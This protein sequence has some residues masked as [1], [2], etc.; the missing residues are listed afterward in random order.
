MSHIIKVKNSDGS[1]RDIEVQ[2]NETVSIVE[3]EI[4]FIDEV[5][6]AVELQ[7]TDNNG[8]EIT[9]ANGDSIVLE[10]LV[11]L[12]ANQ[13]D[14]PVAVLNF[15]TE[16]LELQSIDTYEKLIAA[17][18]ASAAGEENDELETNTLQYVTNDLPLNQG[19]NNSDTDENIRSRSQLNQEVLLEEK[20]DY[21]QII[22]DEVEDNFSVVTSAESLYASVN[23]SFDSTTDALA[24]LNEA[25]E[26]Y[27][28]LSTEIT[29]VKSRVDYN[30]NDS[31]EDLV[32]IMPLL[33][34]A[35]REHMDAADKYHEKIQLVKVDIDKALVSA[36]NAIDVSKSIAQRAE[37]FGVNNSTLNDMVQRAQK[38]FDHIKE[39]HSKN[40]DAI[41][42]A[43][44][45]MAKARENFDASEQLENDVKTDIEAILERANERASEELSE[46]DDA[47][48][49]ANLSELAVEELEEK[50]NTT[51]SEL[52]SLITRVEDSKENV[53]NKVT[54]DTSKELASNAVDMAKEYFDT[55]VDQ[56]QKAED[57]LSKANL[58]KKEALE[59]VRSAEDAYRKS[60]IA[61]EDSDAEVIALNSAKAALDEAESEISEAK[62]DLQTAKDEV[63]MALKKVE[64][65]NTLNSEINN[66]NLGPDANNDTTL[67]NE[68]TTLLIEPSTLLSNDTDEDGDTLTIT[69]VEATENTHGTVSINDEGKVVF[70]PESNYNGETSFNYTISDG[71]G[72]TSSAVVTV[73]VID[74]N[75]APTLTVESTKSV[76]ED[77]TTS[78]TYSASDIDGTATVTA[79]ALHGTVTVNNDGTITYT[80]DANYNGADTITV[81]ATDDD[82]SVVTQTSSITVND[83][84]DAP[85]L[86]VESTKSVNEDGTTSITYSA[87]DI[88]GTATVTATALHGTV[89]V[90]N[91]GTITYTPDANYNG[92]DTITVTATDDDGSVVTQ[93]S[94]ITVN[95]IND[96]PTLTVESTKSVNEDGTTSITYSASDIDGTATVTATALHGTVTVNNDGTITY[97]PDANYNGADTITVTATDDDG[98]VVTQTSSITVNDINDAPT[99]T[100][101]ST[102]SVNEDGTTSITY[103]ASD[104][105]GT[106]TVTATALHG[107]VTVNN[108]GTITYTPDANYNG[109]DTITVTATDDDGSVVTQTSSITVND[110]NDAPVITVGDVTAVED[111]SQVIANV[112]DIDGTI[113]SSNL[114][115][116]NGT[117]TIA[118][119]GDITYTPNANYN[120]TDSVTIE[121][122]DNDGTTTTQTFD[123]DV[124]A[125][126]DGPVA[127]D[128]SP[129]NSQ[130]I[131]AVS[132]GGLGHGIV[133]MDGASGSGYIMYSS[134]NVH[135]RFSDNAIH[136]GNATNLVAVKNIDGQWYY[137]TNTKLVAFT[138]QDGDRLVAEVDFSADT[139][140]MLSGITDTSHQINGINAGYVDGDLAITANRWAG[141]SNAGEFGITG[142]TINVQS[143]DGSLQTNEDNSITIEPSTLLENDS[144]IDGDTLTI[145]SVDAT[146]NTH[147]TVTINED[148]KVVF[149]PDA[150]YNGAASF[151]YT[152]SDGNG[153]TSSA[154]VN[155]NVTS[156]NDLPE[157]TV[158][159]TATVNEDGTLTISS[160]SF[161]ITDVEDGIVA[162]TLSADNGTVEI[163][164]G[165]IVYTPDANYNGT[166]TITVTATDSDGGI[167]TETIAVFVEAVNDG[168]VAVDDSG[169]STVMINENG[170]D[171]A[172]VFDS[173]GDNPELLGGATSV[174]V[175]M[176]ISSTSNNSNSLLSYASS[177][178]NNDFLVF[179]N[180]AG[181]AIGIYVDG[182]S[183][184][185]GIDGSIYD[186]EEKEISVSWD[187]ATGLTSVFVNGEQQGRTV[188]LAK[189]H[190][191]GEDGVL[192]LGQEQDSTGGS[193][194]AN[195]VFSGEY[196]D[197]SISVNGEEKAHWEMQSNS[198]NKIVDSTG[199]YDLSIVG[200]VSVSSINT[201]ISEDTTLLIEPS[202]LLSND[203]D[204]DGD[205][206]TITSVEATENTHG[207]V[208]INDEGKVVFTPESNYNGETS[209]NYTISDGNGGTSSAVVTVSVIDINDA[210]TLTVESTKSV[211][212]DG[213]TSIT[214]SASDIDGTATVTA[215][216]L[217]GTVTVNND[218][219]ITYTPD[220]NYN[221]ADTITVTATDD[222][223]SVVTQTSSITVNDINDAPVITV[224]DVTAVE[225]VSQVIANV[226]DI[227]GTIDS[228]NLT[229]NNGT[230][231]IADNGDITYTPNANYN[232]TD[233]VTIEVTDNDGTTTTQTFDVD[234]AAVNDGPTANDDSTN[235]MVF[236]GSTGYVSSGD[237]L[238]NVF[239][240]S[241]NSFSITANL[242]PESLSEAKT[243]H[244]IKNVFAAKASDSY[245]D[246]F[247]IGIDTDGS[248]LVYIDTVGADTYVDIGNP[249]DIIV[250]EN[251]FISVSYDNGVL[252]ANINGNE[253]TNDTT[254]TTSN[255][256][257][258]Q[259]VGSP[260]TVGASVHI[261]TFFKG[262]IDD[263]QVHSKA[264]SSDEVSTLQ[265][266]GT[267]TNGLELGYNF[268][269]STPLLDS[270]GNGL[271]GT[272]SGTVTSDE[273]ST[274]E[275]TDLVLDTAILLAND[276]DIDGG[277]LTVAS[278]QDATNGSVR[279]EN[280]EVV[281][282]PE[283]NYNGVATFTYTISDGQGGTDTATVTLNVASVNDKPEI[284]T[285]STVTMNEDGTQNI[286]YT[287]SD[288]END[289]VTVTGTSTDGVVTVNENGTLD[290]TPNTNFN[291]TTQIDVIVDDQ[292]GG[293]TTHTI[294]VTVNAVNDNISTVD[295]SDSSV[296]EISS[297]AANGDLTGVTANSIDVDGDNVTYSIVDSDGNEI[298]DGAFS[299]DATTGVVSVNDNSLL[300]SSAT[301]HD[302]TVKATSA[303]GSTA[304]QNFSIGVANESLKAHW[305]FEGNTTD[306]ASADSVSDNG[307][308]RGNAQ[309]TDDNT[310]KLD[311]SGDYMSMGNSTEINK[312]N[313]EGINQRTITIDFKADP[314]GGETQVLYY[315]GGGTRGL[316][317]YMHEGNIAVGGWNKAETRWNG[318][319]LNSDIDVQDGQW[320]QV[321]LVLDGGDDSSQLDG[322]LKGFVDGEKFGEGVGSNLWSH[323]TAN[324][325]KPSG[326][327]LD[328]N[329]DGNADTNNQAWFKG[330]IS[331]AKIYDTAM[332]DA[333]VTNEFNKAEFPENIGIEIN[334]NTEDV[335]GTNDND[336][337]KINEESD[338]SNNIDGGK[339]YDTL[340]I[341][342]DMILDFDNIDVTQLQSIESIDMTNNSTS[343]SIENLDLSDVLKMTENE[344]IDNEIMKILGDGDGTEANSDTLELDKS[345]WKHTEGDTVETEDGETFDVW[346]N[347]DTT[348]FVDDD[349]FISDV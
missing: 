314:T 285:L 328:V 205:T 196:H 20:E 273:I 221:G 341:E 202:T 2:N 326:A 223:G 229:A 131:T 87:S 72:G 50:S 86:T 44:E 79:T 93:T 69:S 259:A 159:S 62:A 201:E 36:Q 153:G 107:T 52:N 183:H 241:S 53:I 151:T 349:I 200:D 155:L 300:D 90:N 54:L 143:A 253:Y 293:V 94:S 272:I 217:H 275:D 117:V 3:G 74:I 209:F 38:N 262:S 255:P 30:S 67:T 98:S 319:W 185:F 322:T 254:W 317:V 243:N 81:T 348:I 231:T 287:I 19:Q 295:D 76:N 329:N 152:I 134:D 240:S 91:D 232:G 331:D 193:L 11:E 237:A 186:G 235:G 288:A 339:G 1:F 181:T 15:Q 45:Q 13:K 142:T 281:F 65:T 198:D 126:N 147:G 108:D 192:M 162:P 327:L 49:V 58:S 340:I 296:N 195:Q 347:N 24:E 16:A 168:P 103:S 333:Q 138:P 17:L 118:D 115:A 207:T 298:T 307:T 125:V 100:V 59:A 104:I 277:T 56:V 263:V 136:S 21:S 301:S 250:G 324:F 18:E 7:I 182:A 64:T 33:K 82:G 178:N 214:Y 47:F 283:P 10:G 289:T 218:G 96:A 85:T 325:G 123:V 334:V 80:P 27:S 133:G 305:T 266:G 180:D 234:V 167:T 345:K 342:N 216:A 258:D 247:E 299:V 256:T 71:N 174:D 311:G 95:D 246:N 187:S 268:K 112:S 252:T 173:R 160:D 239:G 68:D 132:L 291:G 249:G 29:G 113:D 303:D 338:L 163:V 88:D 105:D 165:N 102:K 57:Y 26:N 34:V 137:D 154:T 290:F 188:T 156:V 109:A 191:L 269:S 130:S 270:S 304:T 146:E 148:G 242:N 31:I 99:L 318:T 25:D 116:N 111:V 312:T 306:V 265:G 184:Y 140:T 145:I 236:D 271:N 344:G 176:T 194:D 119:N 278:V 128:D 219:T 228:S 166:D 220:A 213:T 227:D 172:L 9:Y 48:D 171:G 294:D 177:E 248:L 23:S 121:V 149:T 161:S 222:D 206:L 4:V 157:I 316:S 40:E 75:D 46:F 158:Q 267:V 238:N 12:I 141:S 190:T 175:S 346:T 197:V 92:A 233:S 170:T 276:S 226:S 51:E 315:E 208:S 41:K 337:F 122:T 336:T 284:T 215:T 321:T 66:I 204:E 261:D 6:D 42:Y 55:A 77:G 244:Q 83:I 286:A 89:T 22:K 179:S 211:N 210:P 225:D 78:I 37:S 84:N 308:L 292:N 150:N 251:N 330:E 320:H 35:A 110:I 43:Q 302:V 124:A 14:D 310:L 114:T 189:G 101:E 120:G 39:L 297:F 127:S 264:L 332:S 309:I 129:D 199:N 323:A 70:T 257:L 5:L 224:G 282:T 313:G 28:E 135:D 260:F 106:A 8:I 139:V 203:T 230:V 335:V 343:G 60:Q 274:N 169:T 164:D 61:G 279:L 280:G 212:E 73:S 32:E 144:D 97:T 63:E 245:N